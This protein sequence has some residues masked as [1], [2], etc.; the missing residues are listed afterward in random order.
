M[1]ASLKDMIDASAEQDEAVRVLSI[2]DP[3]LHDAIFVTGCIQE[4][5]PSGT[6]HVLVPLQIALDTGRLSERAFLMRPNG[7]RTLLRR[8]L[9]RLLDQLG[10]DWISRLDA[11]LRNGW[12]HGSLDRSSINRWIEQFEHCGSHRWVA[13]GLL[14]S[15]DFWSDARMRD[16]LQLVPETLAGIDCI[17]VNRHTKAGRSADVIANLARKQLDGSSAL[18]N[19]SLLDFREALESPDFTHLLYIEDCILSGNEMERVLLGLL[20]L[21]DPYGT[22]RSKALSRP[23][24]LRTKQVTLRFAVIGNGGL[25]HV[26]QFLAQH[27]LHNIT[28]STDSAHLVPMFTPSGLSALRNGTLYDA[29]DSLRNPD[30]DM[31][32]SVFQFWPEPEKQDRAR[33][34]CEEIGRQLYANYLASQGKQKPLRWIHECA[35]GVRSAALTL[36]FGHS[37]PKETLP[38]FW[39][40]GEIIW[41]GR[42]FIWYPLFEGAE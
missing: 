3:R 18:Q 4:N 19:L 33:H 25:E 6:P 42:P 27:G 2:P 39:A 11:F 16:A 40:K 41:K 31:Q 38:L 37:V 1:K 17:C 34:F 15:L 12:H 13:E 24:M 7:I 35:L 22:A 14:K 9:P 36:A 10:L 8:D 32:R 20:G 26:R 23:D 5:L 30:Q 29:K 28:V 21:P